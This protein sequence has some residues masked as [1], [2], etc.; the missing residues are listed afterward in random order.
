M[1]EFGPALTLVGG[2]LAIV[3]VVIDAFQRRD[4][5]RS[6]TAENTLLKARVS[7]LEAAVGSLESE[8]TSLKAEG[9]ALKGESQTLKAETARLTAECER[10]R[11][12]LAKAS[13]ADPRRDALREALKGAQH[14]LTDLREDLAGPFCIDPTRRGRVFSEAV[15]SFMKCA[16][17]MTHVLLAGTEFAESEASRIGWH[18]REAA[19]DCVTEQ[20]EKP[21]AAAVAKLLSDGPDH[22]LSSDFVVPPDWWL[23]PTG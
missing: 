3:A 10:L 15:T 8:N 2:V 19:S 5:V 11:Q 21:F 7:T 14:A 6:L 20:S 17:Q 18:L 4:L 1:P 16:A 23:I 12:A 22:V 13:V 9:D